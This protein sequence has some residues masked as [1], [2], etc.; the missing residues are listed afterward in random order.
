MGRLRAD[1]APTSHAHAID[2]SS[3]MASAG[4]DITSEGWHE[5]SSEAQRL[6]REVEHGIADARTAGLYDGA[7]GMS[8]EEMRRR[9]EMRRNTRRDHRQGLGWKLGANVGMCVPY[10]RVRARCCSRARAQGQRP[11]G[12]YLARR[13]GV[14]AA[15]A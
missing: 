4:V 1:Q 6:T 8:S 3:D 13:V 15:H 2:Y 7:V 12:E 14:G 9:E 10:M 11:L 5:L